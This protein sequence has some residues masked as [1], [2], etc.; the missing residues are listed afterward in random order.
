MSDEE[1]FKKEVYELM[2]GYNSKVS[3]YMGGPTEF[4]R[5]VNFNFVSP[6]ALTSR[7]GSTL[8]SGATVSGRITGGIEFERLS[9]SSYVVVSAN[10]NAYTVSGSGYVAI[11]SG[12]SD[13]SLFSFQTVV[14]R[15]FGA[16]GNDFFKFD[17]SGTANYSLPDPTGLTAFP[18]VGGTL[19]GGTY[20]VAYGYLND[21]GYYGP[22]SNLVY[23]SVPGGSTAAITYSG[24]SNVIGYGV[25]AISLYRSLPGGAAVFGS[26]TVGFTTS[27]ID[28]GAALGTRNE[29]PYLWFTMVPRSLS[30]YN[31][32]MFMSGFS[33]MLSTVYWSDVGEPEGVDPTFFTEF[34]T[35]DGDRVTGHVPYQGSLVVFKER[36]F[37]RLS[38]DN[39][40]NFTQVELSDQ[41]GCLSHRASVVYE[42][43]LLFLDSKG[44]V[45]H[46]GANTSVMS[47]KVEPLFSGMNLSVARDN[48]WAIHY[49]KYNEVWFGIPANG[50][51][52][53]NTIIVY[54]YLSNAFTTYEG[55]NASTV[56]MAKGST[57]EKTVFYGGYTG[58]VC[59][60]GASLYTDEGRG[61]TAL[62]DTIY[63][64]E[65]ART[66][67][68]LWRRFYVDVDQ[69]GSQAGGTIACNFVSNYGTSAPLTRYVSTDSFQ[70]RVDFGIPAKSIQAC[71]SYYSA[72]GPIKINGYA[73]ESRYLRSV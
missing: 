10:T 42:N 67:T 29:P 8:Y 60:F 46:D 20:A 16:N 41:Y 69:N 59:C 50:A 12:L 39:P 57:T 36:S 43:I 49:R 65:G 7:P 71:V 48:A 2:G 13:S 5:L 32:Q 14:D 51:S 17:G 45:R 73:F 55:V 9:G 44:I 15:L 28:L 72:S 11:R 24:M 37:H 6:G 66:G 56:F 58:Q 61:F 18:S 62:F 52:Y 25:S 38:G 68:R 64:V 70:T 40:D 27:Y 47:N 22:V 26:T 63:H 4:R 21:R 19:A 1:N 34:R 33:T 35:N 31:N 54:D 30:L 23:V 3:T 53:L